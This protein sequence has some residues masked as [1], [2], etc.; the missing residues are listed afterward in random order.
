LL[1]FWKYARKNNFH[2]HDERDR[3]T[4]ATRR[5]AR[6]EPKKKTKKKKIIHSEN[7]LSDRKEKPNILRTPSRSRGAALST[8]DVKFNL[9]DSYGKIERELFGKINYSSGD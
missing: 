5:D 6:E 7:T 1:Y 8:L 4:R 3:D 2:S 9:S